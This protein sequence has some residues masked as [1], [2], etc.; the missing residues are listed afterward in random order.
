MGLYFAKVQSE[1]GTDLWINMSDVSLIDVG[2]NVIWF[3]NGTYRDV[4]DVT[5]LIN[6]IK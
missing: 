6:E 4:K 3:K 1:N 5:P 2:N